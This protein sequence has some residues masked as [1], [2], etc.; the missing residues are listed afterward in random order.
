MTTQPV[1]AP[2]APTTTPNNVTA[3]PT[4][5][6]YVKSPAETEA[7]VLAGFDDARVSYQSSQLETERAY[8][9]RAGVPDPNPPFEPPAEPDVVAEAPPAPA[10]P[11]AP[12]SAKKPS[13]TKK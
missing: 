5:H 3:Y 9:H 11:P 2:A 7:A 8:R 13:S 6:L 4:D 10:P 12:R 1:E